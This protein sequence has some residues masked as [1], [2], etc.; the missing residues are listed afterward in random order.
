VISS[1][2]VIDV[3]SRLEPDPNEQSIALLRSILLAL[4]QSAIPNETPSVPP[5]QG[6]PPNGTIAVTGLMYASLL[7]SLLAAFIAMLGRQWLNQYLR[8]TGGSLIERCGD[9]Q[10]KCDGLAK[11][12]FHLFVESPPVMLQL[13]LLLLACGLC[14]R[15]WSI[16]IAVASILITLTAIGSLF[17]LAIVVA[18]MSSYA[19]PFQTP[20]SIALRGPWKKVRCRIVSVVGHYKEAISW[21][22]RV[23]NRRTWQP[24]HQSPPITPLESVQTKQPEPWLKPEDLAIVRRTNSNDVR[25][26]LWI[27]RNITDPEALDAAI[28]FAATI[29]WFE[30]GI[31]VEPPYDLIVSTLEACFDPTARL[32]P[33]LGDRA[34][35]SAQAILWIHVRARCISEKL[36]HRYPLPVIRCSTTSLDCDLVDLLGVYRGL[37]TPEVIAWMHRTTP[38]LT[39]MHLQWTSNALLHLSWAN[40]S[41]P[42][43]FNS[44]RC[45][46]DE[47]DW[48]LIP[49]NAMLNLLLTWCIVLGW[50]VEE[51]VLKVQDKSYVTSC[52]CPSISCSPR[53]SVSDQLERILSQFSQAITS[54]THPSHPQFEYLPQVL[55]ELT[56]LRNRPSN[57]TV[58]AYEWCSNLCRNC[59][60][61]ADREELLPLSLEIGFRHLDH[62]YQWISAE[63]AHT[64]YHKQMVDIV[65]HS[66]DEEFI[67]DLLHAWTSTS[68]SHGPHPSLSTCAR[69]LVCLQPTS[70]RLRR[71][72]IRSIELIGYKEFEGVGLE[73]FVELLDD[74]N[75]GVEDVE[76]REQ[77]ALLLLNVIHSSEG[78]QGLSHQYWELFWELT[79]SCSWR[80]G[81]YIWSSHITAFL[82]DSQEWDKLECWIGVIWMVWPP[83]TGG[84]IEDIEHAMLSLFCQRPGAIQ[85]LKQRM[86]HWG[87][88]NDYQVPESFQ[89]ICERGCC[90]VAR[91]DAR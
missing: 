7:T 69:H 55:L 45:Y 25:C 24:H 70:E 23:W 8:N 10:R 30:D 4:N 89:R 15:M 50:P 82:K 42:G 34:Y 38:G 40:R 49:L 11:W 22:R 86:E 48:N 28:R 52:F 31:N 35:H 19:C 37:D 85:K 27:L 66:R 73:Q 88:E 5:V 64:K 67:A 59:S 32:H 20:V 65:F 17:Y 18:S 16:N 26:V 83:G 58:M 1:A 53:L 62:Q 36:S 71:L 13:S 75:V 68:E 33:R 72:V 90:E 51:E 81:G 54:A 63:L 46:P 77:W 80:L 9:R 79:I 60:S 47:R 84:T 76:D 56:E 14:R 91:W 74:L 3:H 44:I 43:T 12:S 41:V 57:F 61:L 2:F 6:V 29:R 78:I 39:P 21:T 87:K